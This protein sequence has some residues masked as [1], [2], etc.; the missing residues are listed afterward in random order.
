M[1]QSFK[2]ANW[3]QLIYCYDLGKIHFNSKAMSLRN[4]SNLL[5]TKTIDKSDPY[6][7]FY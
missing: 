6:G 5:Q 4:H 3:E 2:S 7:Y 1:S